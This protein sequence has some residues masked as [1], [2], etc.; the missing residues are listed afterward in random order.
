MSNKNH[1]WIVVANKC[2]AKIFRLV[3]FPKIEEITFLEHPESRL[4]NQDLVSSKPGRNFQSG[5]TT[6]HAYQPEVEPKQQEAIKFA[7]KV[8]H[9]LET[10]FQKG[11]FNR[12]YIL[13]EPGFLGLLRQHLHSEVQKIIVAEVPKDLTTSEPTLI[14][15]QLSEI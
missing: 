6:R 14:E 11:E 4:H 3:K 8:A 2:Q 13:A 1:T 5:G 12:L 9:H 7:I 10:A 15:H